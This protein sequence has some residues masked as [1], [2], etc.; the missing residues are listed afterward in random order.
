MWSIEQSFLG[1]RGI[2]NKRL[3]LLFR[4]LVQQVHFREQFFFSLVSEV[5]IIRLA[6]T[7]LNCRLE[8]IVLY[9]WRIPLFKGLQNPLD[10]SFAAYDILPVMSADDVIILVYEPVC[11][12][13]EYHHLMV[14]PIER[15]G[16]LTVWQ[17]WIRFYQLHHTGVASPESDILFLHNLIQPFEEFVKCKIGYRLRH[18]NGIAP[19]TIYDISR[20]HIVHILVSVIFLDIPLLYQFVSNIHKR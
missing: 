15:R 9:Q 10:D 19:E 13:V 4:I 18:I 8:N 12:D 3:V 16:Y 11:K 14:I 1:E 20:Y 17:M 2:W 7:I 6:H 5:V